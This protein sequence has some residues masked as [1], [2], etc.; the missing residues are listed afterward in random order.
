MKE[1]KKLLEKYEHFEISEENLYYKVEDP[2]N[3]E[4]FIKDQGIS[5]QNSMQKGIFGSGIYLAKQAKSFHSVGFLHKKNEKNQMILCRTLVGVVQKAT[6][7]NCER[8]NL[9]LIENSINKTHD[10][11]EYVSTQG[12]I[13]VLF[14]E[15]R[16]YPEYVID[17]SF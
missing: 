1:K 6:Q 7:A 15:N 9:D 17:Y 2:N 5:L 16:V 14:N 11:L 10:S 4:A 8:K 12:V 3:L 13:I